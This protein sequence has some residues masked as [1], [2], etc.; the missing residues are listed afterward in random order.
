MSAVRKDTYGP[1]AEI[2]S[3]IAAAQRSNDCAVPGLEESGVETSGYTVHV[4]D[5]HIT[6]VMPPS[7][8]SPTE[9]KPAAPTDYSTTDTCDPSKVPRTFGSIAWRHQ[10]PANDNYTTIRTILN[11]AFNHAATGKGKERH[12]RNLPFDKQPMLETTRLVGHGFPLGQA[13]KKAGEAA[14]MIER[15]E[16]DAAEAECLGAINYLAGAVAWMR[17]QREK[18]MAEYG[19]G[20]IPPAPACAGAAA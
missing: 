11:A 1:A 14:G 12:A 8:W 13:I 4:K 7:E 18:E 2:A 15:G 3:R 5:S 9:G 19:Q 20:Y 10:Q 17:E 6:A 16:L